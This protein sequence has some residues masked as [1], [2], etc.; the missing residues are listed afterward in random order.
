[1]GL[2]AESVVLQGWAGVRCCDVVW[3]ELH[4]TTFPFPVFGF[5]VHFLSLYPVCGPQDLDNMDTAHLYFFKAGP[6]AEVLLQVG[7]T[8][9]LV[10]DGSR[11]THYGKLYGS[12]FVFGGHGYVLEMSPG[13]IMLMDARKR[14]TMPGYCTTMSNPTST[15]IET[16]HHYL[17]HSNHNRS[18]CFDVC[19]DVCAMRAAR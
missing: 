12:D 7:R 5:L 8:Y 11:I 6:V 9:A 19:D 16:P 17:S 2:Y 18:A 4:N 3:H 10:F 14:R 1:M 15:A 13:G